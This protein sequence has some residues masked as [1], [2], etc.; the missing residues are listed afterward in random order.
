MVF[1]VCPDAPRLRVSGTSHVARSR[2]QLPR[3]CVHTS[4]SS[5]TAPV[6][7]IYLVDLKKLTTDS[8]AQAR[9]CSWL[10]QKPSVVHVQ[11]AFVWRTARLGRAFRPVDW[12]DGSGTAGWLTGGTMHGCLTEHGD[13]AAGWWM[14]CWLD[15]WLD[16]VR[17][18]LLDERM[19][20]CLLRRRTHEVHRRQELFPLTRWIRAGRTGLHN[21]WYP[22][23]TPAHAQCWRA[24]KTQCPLR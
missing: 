9:R 14:D 12:L 6:R 24:A 23:G 17:D 13:W 15:G 2:T 16:G 3:V 11:H 4:A 8:S 7:P 20:D 22:E 19:I 5:V 18:G 1:T 21:H 10:A